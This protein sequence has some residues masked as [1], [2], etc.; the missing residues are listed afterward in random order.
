M[1][2][3]IITILN[4]I[5]LGTGLIIIVGLI[6]LLIGILKKAKKYKDMYD[7]EKIEKVIKEDLLKVLNL[8]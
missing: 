2:E 8:I 3:Q 4:Y 7:K 5:P 6:S 1:N